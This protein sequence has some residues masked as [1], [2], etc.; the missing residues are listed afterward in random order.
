MSINLNSAPYNK[1]QR[2]QNSI[3]KNKPCQLLKQ[4][5]QKK[6]SFGSIKADLIKKQLVEIADYYTYGKN[7]VI[8]KV[9]EGFISRIAKEITNPNSNNM[10]VGITGESASGKSTFVKKITDTIKD[11]I[12][13]IRGD[14]YYKDISDLKKKY[15]GFEGVVNSG[16]SFDVPSALNLDLLKKDLGQ[17]LKGNNVKIPYYDMATSSSIPYKIDIKPAKVILLDSIFAL[18]NKLRDIIDIGV[19]VD[20]KPEIR[21]QRWFSRINSR[22]KDSKTV[23]KQFADANEKAKNHI[24]PTKD[25][26][27]IV[28]N[29]ET[30]LDVIAQFA[31]DLGSI[32][33]K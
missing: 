2:T 30:P 6:L 4:P 29:G 32:F 24:I 28:L 17:L 20:T 33:K 9:K 18:N 19:Y 3:R 26:A 22:Q 10:V 23:Q 16:Y 21:T 7:P 27:D 15:G 5:I 25:K 13:L 1:L 11:K 14:N 12:T 8:L 31:N